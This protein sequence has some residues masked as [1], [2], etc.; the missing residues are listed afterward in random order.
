[1]TEERYKK[2]M[3]L[4]SSRR[5]YVALINNI[6]RAITIIIFLSYVLAVVYTFFKM[7]K[8]LIPLVAVPG[9]SFVALSLFRRRYD[10]A[11][12]YEVY[13][14]QPVLKKDT[15]GKSF[16]SRHIFS[17]FVIGT[18]FMVLAVNDASPAGVAIAAVMMVMGLLQ[19][20]LRVIGGVH[21]IR[22]VI[23]GA[24]IGILAGIVGVI[25]IISP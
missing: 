11:R 23:V 8:L 20:V 15:S 7:P 16:P 17:V 6:D 9:V 21:F 2:M 3:A 22:D 14:T 10:A 13:A 5:I 18:T 12:P 1:M 24:L 25:F 19:A 4:L